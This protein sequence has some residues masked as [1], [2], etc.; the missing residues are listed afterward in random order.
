V[1]WLFK[2]WA[3]GPPSHDPLVA[4]KFRCL[5]PAVRFDFCVRACCLQEL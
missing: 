1:A 2:K 5:A 3:M 4:E